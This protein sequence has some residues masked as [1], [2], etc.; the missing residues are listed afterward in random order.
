MNLNTQRLCLIKIKSSKDV[1]QTLI[2]KKKLIWDFQDFF[3]LISPK[4]T[5]LAKLSAFL[6]EKVLSSRLDP[7]TV[8][9]L[10]EGNL[11]IEVEHRK[12]AK[13]I[14]KMKTLHNI[15]M[16]TFLYARLNTKGVIRSKELSLATSE[17]ITS[18]LGK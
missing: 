1:F 8:R 18:S 6:I 9:K 5:P 16:K 14:I 12:H 3:V 15:K 11:L 13:N 4:E 7:K 2:L 10:R 17:E